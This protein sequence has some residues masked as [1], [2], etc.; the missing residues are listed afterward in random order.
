MKTNKKK[1]V[2]SLTRSHSDRTAISAQ[3]EDV[4]VQKLALK[5]VA[6][7]DVGKVLVCYYNK[8]GVL[9]RK[10]RSLDVPVE[11]KW[12]P[13][14]CDEKQYVPDKYP[15]QNGDEEET[16]T[17]SPLHAACRKGNLTKAKSILSQGLVDINRRDGN[18]GKTPLMVAAQGGH[19]RIFDF[20]I[21]KGANK[22]DVDNDGKNIL[23]WACKGGHVGMVK[24][25]L[26]LYGVDINKNKV[27]PLMQAAYRGYTDVFEFLVCMGA[28]VSQVDD[29]GD[30]V[31]HWACKGGNRGMVKYLLSLCSLD[32]I[33]NRRG[34]G[35]ATPLMVAASAGHRDVFEILVRKGA[36]VSE[37]DNT[38]NSVLHYSS[39]GGNVGLV[40]HITSM[41]NIKDRNKSGQTAAMIAMTLKKYHVYNFLVSQGCPVK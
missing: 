22:S 15:R 9:M 18:H 6:F 4:E 29:S 39:L 16:I 28:N 30:N 25:L 14:H 8:E 24:C 35:G 34:R 33:I 13:H 21:R 41:V 20:L 12:K 11:D 3:G 31:L 1:G 27:S 26:R 17:G 7:E 10:Y 2:V 36:N 19:C 5:A 32:N 38:G 23:H 40:E 37:V